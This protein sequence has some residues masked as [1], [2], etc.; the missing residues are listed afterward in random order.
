MSKDLLGMLWVTCNNCGWVHVGV[1]AKYVLEQTASF[2]DYWDAADEHTR[3]SFWNEEVRGPMPD[4]YPRN[5]HA[6]GYRKCLRCG[7][8]YTNF[9]DFKEG[10]CP[11]GCTIGPILMREQP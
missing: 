5:E 11:E 9:R 1:T 2:G 10:D 4:F 3:S 8:I 6:D 7:G